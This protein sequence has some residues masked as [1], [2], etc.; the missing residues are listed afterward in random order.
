MVIRQVLKKG[1]F[2]IA[3]A[4]AVI[5]NDDY[6]VGDWAVYN[7][8]SWDKVDNT[9]SVAS[10]NTKTGTVTLD[11]TDLQVGNGDTTTIQT[12]I[13]YIYS[14]LLSRYTKDETYNKDEVDALVVGGG[15]GDV[16]L[17]GLIED[18]QDGTI[19]VGKATKD[20][21]GKVITSTYATKVEKCFKA[22]HKRKRTSQWLR[23][24]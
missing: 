3:I 19:I 22:K 18:L 7:G 17:D 14:E 5:S 21:S 10:V 11:G 24:S 8:V 16:N 1:W 13:G 12:K 23:K 9:D 2:Y 4:N 15:G 6:K 20:A